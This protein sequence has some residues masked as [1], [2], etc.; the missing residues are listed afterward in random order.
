MFKLSIEK[1]FTEWINL[2]H[3]LEKSLNPLQEIWDF[4]NTSPFTPYNRKID[5]YYPKSWPSPWEIIAENTYDDFT[6]ALM[7]SWTLKLT[8]KF[9]NSRIEIRTMLD[10]TQNRQYNLIFVDENY[11]INFDDNGPVEINNYIS[12]LKLENLIEIDRPR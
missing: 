10:E 11:I 9:K 7:I 5:P 2:R 3:S 8:E 6:K 12:S 1:R 4:W